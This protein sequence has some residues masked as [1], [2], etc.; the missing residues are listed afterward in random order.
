S[1]ANLTGSYREFKKNIVKEIKKGREI[2]KKLGPDG[3][4]KRKKF[5][6]DACRRVGLQMEYR[7][8]QEKVGK[9]IQSQAADDPILVNKSRLSS[10]IS[11]L[12]DDFIKSNDHS[13]KLKWTFYILKLFRGNSVLADN[14]PR[15]FTVGH[16]LTLFSLPSD[17]KKLNDELSKL[18]DDVFLGQETQQRFIEQLKQLKEQET[19]LI[20]ENSE[21]QASE[22][23]GVSISKDEAKKSVVS[24]KSSNF[25]RATPDKSKTEKRN[26]FGEMLFETRVNS[27]ISK[28]AQIKNDKELTAA[29]DRLMNNYLGSE[30]DKSKYSK[31]LIKR[32]RYKQFIDN[33]KDTLEKCFGIF[34]KYKKQGHGS[35]DLP[36]ETLDF[37]RDVYTA[38]DKNELEK[39]A[40][41][42]FDYY[43]ID[44]ERW[45]NQR[46]AI[47][48]A[49]T[50]HIFNIQNELSDSQKDSNINRN[51]KYK[52]TLTQKA[53]KQA[54]TE[55]EGKEFLARG[56]P[57]VMT[58][59]EISIPSTFENMKKESMQVLTEMFK[60]GDEKLWPIATEKFNTL[61][62]LSPSQGV[63]AD[64]RKE[65]EGSVFRDK[66]A[67]M[68]IIGNW[69]SIFESGNTKEYEKLF[70]EKLNEG[71]SYNISGVRGKL[72]DL[73]SFIWLI[74]VD[75]DP[76]TRE[77]KFEMLMKEL[78]NKIRKTTKDNFGSVMNE[79]KGKVKKV[80]SGTTPPPASLPPEAINM[81]S[82]DRRTAE[83]KRFG[84]NPAKPLP[85]TPQ[86]NR[87]PQKPLPP[88]PKNQKSS[89]PPQKPLP[90]NPSGSTEDNLT[91]EQKRFGINPDKP[92]PQ[93]PQ[94]SSTPKNPQPPSPST[95]DKNSATKPLSNPSG[96]MLDGNNKFGNRRRV[97]PPT[98][99]N[100]IT[101]H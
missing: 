95:Q 15:G 51:I 40:Q 30:G 25:L 70:G 96:K 84:I 73:L 23:F 13:E 99:T 47:K 12:N 90:P 29:L 44:D 53:P 21:R 71:G 58:T 75:Y 26:K 50:E 77:Q 67:R 94:R 101:S 33:E 63:S 17:L 11:S 46:G 35:I 39:F 68:Q 98:G 5:Y 3:E 69:R 38:I 4:K 48:P 93:P 78:D 91:A 66:S 83:Q 97:G 80:D 85:P 65:V 49:L 86:R 62:R 7:I 6:N 81:P 72:Y 36:K 24:E 34:L 74:Y 54:T 52:I 16:F 41:K 43:Y 89:G 42:V 61:K 1:V 10:N 45:L 59:K 9:I 92:L 60:R 87:P 20:S 14:I 100:S 28:L 37:Y 27:Q 55:A 82:E 79:L 18:G 56:T 88:N 2:L 22:Y 19:T 76:N 57:S 32:V 64:V 8:M 31:S